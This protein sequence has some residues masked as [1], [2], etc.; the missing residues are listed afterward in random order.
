MKVINH[1]SIYFFVLLISFSSIKNG[2]M[3]GFY[4]SNQDSFIELF[5]V[6]K[7]KPELHCDGK[8]ELSKLI[9]RGENHDRKSFDF[10]TKDVMFVYCLID[11]KPPIKY[12]QKPITKSIYSNSYSFLMLSKDNPPPEIA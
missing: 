12:Q 10:L 5:C 3:L 7:D 4:T 2:L 9:D 6:N 1:I 11:F 8:C